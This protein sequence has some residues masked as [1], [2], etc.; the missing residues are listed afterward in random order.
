MIYLASQATPPDPAVLS[1]NIIAFCKDFTGARNLFREWPADLE[2]RG[3]NSALLWLRLS[4]VKLL[5]L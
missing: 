2:T 3:I 5:R 4:R 1:P